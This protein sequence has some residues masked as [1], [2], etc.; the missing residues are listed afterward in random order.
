MIYCYIKKKCLK[1]FNIVYIMFSCFVIS[2]HFPI[3]RL[4]GKNVI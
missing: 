3:I 2:V 4:L 1:C